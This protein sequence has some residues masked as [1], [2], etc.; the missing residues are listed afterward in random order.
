MFWII[1]FVCLAIALIVADIYTHGRN[2]TFFTILFYGVFFTYW[3]LSTNIQ[4]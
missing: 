4:S 2:E 3:N 1:L